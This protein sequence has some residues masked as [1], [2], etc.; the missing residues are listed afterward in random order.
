MSPHNQSVPTHLRN[1]MT[2]PKK[3]KSDLARAA[4][5]D[6]LVVDT[7][8]VSALVGLEA[9]SEGIGPVKGNSSRAAVDGE[10]IRA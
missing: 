5:A 3:R 7:G 2:S 8:K 1:E 10:V 4:E 6:V 9:L